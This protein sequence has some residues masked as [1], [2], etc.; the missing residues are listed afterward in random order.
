ME[1]KISSSSPVLN[2]AGTNANDHLTSCG[3]PSA[4]SSSLYVQA[5]SGSLKYNCAFAKPSTKTKTI[6]NKINDGA[7]TGNNVNDNH[8]K[9]KRD[10]ECPDY[11]AH[12]APQK[13]AKAGDPDSSKTDSGNHINR[14]HI[15]GNHVKGKRDDECPDHQAHRAP[16]KRA[17][18]GDEPDNSKKFKEDETDKDEHI[19]DLNLLL[20]SLKWQSK[21]D[22]IQSNS[23]AIKQFLSRLETD[24]AALTVLHDKLKKQEGDVQPNYNEQ[25]KLV[26]QK[27][28]QTANLN[29]KEQEIHALREKLA[30][31]EKDRDICKNNISQIDNNLN[32][33][34]KGRLD[35]L[36]LI[37]HIKGQIAETAKNANEELVLYEK[38]ISDIEN[39]LTVL[40]EINQEHLEELKFINA[41]DYQQYYKIKAKQIEDDKTR[42]LDIKERF[43]GLTSFC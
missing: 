22:L 26:Y 35:K 9:G 30:V 36:A 5:A 40:K 34:E 31:A 21:R 14:D 16:Q 18:A 28:L 39:S 25:N 17:K 37:E 23:D 13:S 2:G 43:A 32:F 6:H 42:L 11:Q 38:Y 20:T 4:V 29:A 10:D 33:N 12:R 7:D 1:T 24:K 19:K 8:V 27:I 41:G 3:R 15:N